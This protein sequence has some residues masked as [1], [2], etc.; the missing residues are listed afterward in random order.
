M[1]IF[2]QRP[3]RKYLCAFTAATVDP[4]LPEALLE[5]RI[6]RISLAVISLRII[7]SNDISRKVCSVADKFGA[8]VRGFVV[9]I[10]KKKKKNKGPQQSREKGFDESRF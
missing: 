6:N 4:L 7:E 2:W 5:Y 10:K 8:N 9:S 3:R 1:K